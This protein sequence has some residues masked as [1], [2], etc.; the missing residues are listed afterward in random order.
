L[1]Q[2][3]SHLQRN[4]FNART[5]LWNGKEEPEFIE[6]IVQYGIGFTFNIN[7]ARDWLDLQSMTRDFDFNNTAKG[8]MKASSFAGSGLQI[9]LRDNYNISESLFVCQYN[10]FS[11]HSPN[12]FAQEGHTFNY[13]H[14]LD[15]LIIPDITQTDDSLKSTPPNIRNCFFED[16]R[17]LKYF[18]AYTKAACELECKSYLIYDYCNCIPFFLPRNDSMTVCDVYNLMCYYNFM[19]ME[20]NENIKLN[21]TEGVC[22]CLD[23]CNSI[24]YG[25]QLNNIKYDEHYNV[26]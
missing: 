7:D 11:V 10:K 2:N 26:G 21:E 25:I 13:G 5:A 22:G 15:I 18:K 9:A 19:T 20:F 24:K 16:E 17:K 4:W 8:L 1:K 23:D 6:T 3:G 14:S 12:Q